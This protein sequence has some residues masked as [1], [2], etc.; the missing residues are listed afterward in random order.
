VTELLETKKK[1]RGTPTQWDFKMTHKEFPGQV[2]KGSW[3]VGLG[4]AQEEG[5]EVLGGLFALA[6]D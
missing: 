5:A 4:T 6:V 1:V 2:A 3:R